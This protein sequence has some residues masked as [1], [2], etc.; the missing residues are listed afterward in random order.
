MIHYGFLSLFGNDPMHNHFT[1][2]LSST[3]YGG[4]RHHIMGRGT[5]IYKDNIRH[6]I[7][8]SSVRSL[9]KSNWVIGND[10]YIGRED[11]YREPK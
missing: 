2:L 10:V 1:T 7:A 11:V 9:V 6:C 5:Y 8:L 4:D 3:S